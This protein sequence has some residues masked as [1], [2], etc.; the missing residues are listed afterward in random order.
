MSKPVTPT[1]YIRCLNHGLIRKLSDLLDPQDA[2][3]KLAVDI[4]KPTGEPRYTQLHIR[5]FEG[6]IRMGKSPTEE[7]LFDWGTTNTTIRELV[8]ILVQ[9]NFLA[10]ASL[11]LPDA[12]PSPTLSYSS[13][14]TIAFQETMP[15]PVNECQPM[16]LVSN[17]Q[18]TQQYPENCTVKET[19]LLVNSSSEK[20]SAPDSLK[21]SL[22]S[23]GFQ[24]LKQKTGNFDCR[25]VAE[26]GS[27]IGEGGFGT[28]YRGC[29][30]NRMVAVKKLTAMPNVSIEELKLQFNQEIKTMAKCHHENLVELFGFSNDGDHL[31]LVYPYMPNGSLLDKLACLGDTAP[32]SWS[33]R[34]SIALGT[35]KGL[36][37]LHENGHIH[38][39]VKSANILLD[40]MF[41]PKLSDFGLARASA[42]LSQTM[43]TERI[44]GTT[45]YMAPEALRG[46]IT[47][48][49]DVFSFGVVLL[50]LITGL[51]PMEENREPQLLL[52]IK[53]EIEDEEK[54]IEDYAD[55]KMDWDS[56]SVQKTY[57]IASQCLNEK[58]NK[59]PDI[60]KV[61]ESLQEIS[62]IS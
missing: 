30:N 20:N 49:S 32:L 28:V 17:N 14:E 18:L 35:S 5:R 8:E 55:K 62:L 58:K 36:K 46:E 44:V 1:S 38:R 21:N 23:F 12:V 53:E 37:Y 50:E 15:V 31:C 41:V 22:Q 61:N 7:L 25:S 57:L 45:A 13:S 39:D 19:E 27:K 54:T 24:E 52:E 34:C 40:G 59:R 2:W 11:L 9:N 3:K 33:I 42:Q 48:K 6:V 56:V 51:K 29:I 26:G 4:Q 10:A 16:L 60:K 47:P 43:L